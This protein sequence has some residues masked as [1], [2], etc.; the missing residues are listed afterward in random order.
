[1]NFKCSKHKSNEGFINENNEW[2]CWECY[3]NIK[4]T[5]CYNFSEMMSSFRI[6]NSTII[7]SLSKEVE[8]TPLPI[9]IRLRENLGKFMISVDDSRKG[10]GVSHMEFYLFSKESKAREFFELLRNELQ[11]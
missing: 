8:E 2:I 4:D 7:I 5:K 1:L 11:M 3:N 6:E 9:I 10:I